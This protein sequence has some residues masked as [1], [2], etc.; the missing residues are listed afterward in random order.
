MVNLK[1]AKKETL[2]LQCTKKGNDIFTDANDI[3][4]IW[5]EHFCQVFSPSTYVDQDR[6]KEIIERVSSIRRMAMQE[7]DIFSIDQHNVHTIISNLK[8]NKAC[9]HD[10]ISYEHIKYG[11]KLLM[12]HLTHLFNIL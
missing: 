2:Q 5:Y 10:G 6:E 3:S 1:P 8:Q 4:E 9:G 7:D 12:N 11:G